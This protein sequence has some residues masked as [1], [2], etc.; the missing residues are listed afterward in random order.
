MKNDLTHPKLL[1]VISLIYNVD[2]P[3]EQT[4]ASMLNILVY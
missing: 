3:V 4:K 1:T 2:L